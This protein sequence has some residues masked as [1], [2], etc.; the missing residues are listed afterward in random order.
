[1]VLREKF[2]VL[3]AFLQNLASKLSFSESIFTYF[4]ETF[5][6]YR[7]AVPEMDVTV[8]IP[9]ISKI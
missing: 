9:L 6:L 5:F 8:Y 3:S 4:P 7:V 1:M 2:I